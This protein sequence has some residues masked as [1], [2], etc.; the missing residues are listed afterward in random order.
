[1]DSFSQSS[2][3]LVRTPG[4]SLKAFGFS[5]I[6]SICEIG[7]FALVGFAFGIHEIEPLVCGYVLATLFA[8]VSFIPQGV[9]VVEAAVMVGFGLFG[10]NTAMGMATVLVY[11]GIVFWLPFLIG[12]IVI[13]RMGFKRGKAKEESGRS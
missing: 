7:C 3:Q 8:M 13:Q 2:K 10:I 12:A 6:A 9:G 4:R 5:L 11:R 1:M